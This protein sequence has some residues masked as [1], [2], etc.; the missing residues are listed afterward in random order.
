MLTTVEPGI[1]ADVDIANAIYT[2]P[3][4]SALVTPT[5]EEDEV[6]KGKEGSGVGIEDL[7]VVKE[8]EIG[9]S[10]IPATVSSSEER[11]SPAKPWRGH[12]VSWR[13]TR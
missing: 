1:V 8:A 2:I 4:V 3:E 12:L 13:P 11:G 10:P 7:P 9:A 5:L 6:A